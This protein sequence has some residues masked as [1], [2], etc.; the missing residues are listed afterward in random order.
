MKVQYE[1]E[2]NSFFETHHCPTKIIKGYGMTEICAAVCT[3]ALPECNRSGSVGIPFT[4][5]VVSIFHPETGKELSYNESGEVC[6]QGPH[7]MLGYYKNEQETSHVLRKHPDGSV[8]LHSGDMGYM[9]EDGCL[10]IQGRIKSMIIRGDG[11]KVFPNLVEQTVM[12]CEDVYACAVIGA[13]DPSF[14]QGQRP[15]VFVVRRDGYTGTDEVLKE[16]LQK[17][18]REELPEYALPMDYRF[19]N[20][21]PLTGIGK[22]D[23]LSLEKELES[24]SRN[25]A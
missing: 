2:V 10:F 18:C 7:V 22:V 4:H 1:E 3:T 5:S 20:V 21:L 12:M 24:P 8:W 6:M 9:D 17:L 13:D 23:Y 19:I 14:S 25:P 15:F 11:F 16:R